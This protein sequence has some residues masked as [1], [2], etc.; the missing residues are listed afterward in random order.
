MQKLLLPFTSALV[1]EK[2]TD[3]EIEH[4]IQNADCDN[5]GLIDFVEFKRMMGVQS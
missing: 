5:D 2:F 3:T 1:G 4:M